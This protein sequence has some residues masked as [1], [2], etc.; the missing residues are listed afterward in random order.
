L[1]IYYSPFTIPM[2][3]YPIYLH[4]LKNALTI[5]VGG[6]PVGERKVR[7]L[8]AAE[9]RIRLISPTATAQLSAWAAS[10][11]LE[12]WARA[13]QPG[14]L[15]GALLV[16]A[17]TNQ[18]SVNAQVAEAAT[19]GG[20]LC[21]VADA[22]SEGHFHLPALYR[23]ADLTVAVGTNGTDPRL[24]QQIRDQIAQLLSP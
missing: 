1:I 16:F 8:L 13:Y 5:V 14:D 19:L 23:S 10:G 17:A 9:A 15:Q 2:P 11:R 18:R 3:A 4:N 7:G 24:A 12:W 20:A 6:G 21:N 22:P